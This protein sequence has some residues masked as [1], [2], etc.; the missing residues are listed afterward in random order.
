MTN[1]NKDTQAQGVVELEQVLTGLAVEIINYDHRMTKA[2]APD[3]RFIH[4]YTAPAKKAIQVLI[5]S[6]ADR[7][8]IAELNAL[9]QDMLSR[10]LTPG[11]GHGED[12][13]RVLGVIEDRIAALAE[14]KEIGK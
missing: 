7:R 12:N 1:P 2:N 6:E 14:P 9:W 3:V 13:G 10:G 4:K 11:S 8:V 5:N